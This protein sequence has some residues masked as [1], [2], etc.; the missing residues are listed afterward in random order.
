[1]QNLLLLLPVLALVLAAA[2]A[3][4]SQ[5]KPLIPIILRR[6]GLAADETT[7]GARFTL[8]FACRVH[9]IQHSCEKLA[10]STPHTDVDVTVKA[11]STDL[12]SARAALVDGSA[13]VT[14][15]TITASLS[16]VDGAL[17]IAAG[18]ILYLDV[19][20]T[21]G[22]SPLTDLSATVWVSRS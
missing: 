18:V 6:V 9:A 2:Q 5:Q 3:F 8:P 19:D 4:P 20:I 12:Q 11:G 21:G 14:G 16:T 7:G 13:I 1:M 17:N 22:S 10:G 15:G